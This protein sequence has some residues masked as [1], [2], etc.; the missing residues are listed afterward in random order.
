M[1]FVL[2]CLLCSDWNTM[3]HW[4]P[5]MPSSSSHG[6]NGSM[7]EVTFSSYPCH[8]PSCY[9]LNPRQCHMDSTSSMLLSEVHSPETETTEQYEHQQALSIYKNHGSRLSC[10]CENSRREYVM[11]G[12]RLVSQNV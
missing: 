1:L 11:L 7:P 6:S 5:E 10:V 4:T 2:D 12:C 8:V 9:A 3:S